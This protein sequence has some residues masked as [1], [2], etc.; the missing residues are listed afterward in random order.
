MGIDFIDLKVA[1]GLYFE[2]I[3][4][5]VIIRNYRLLCDCPIAVDYI[6]EINITNCQKFK[7]GLLLLMGLP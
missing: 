6:L 4:L 2:I 7:N 3:I 1:K 5:F